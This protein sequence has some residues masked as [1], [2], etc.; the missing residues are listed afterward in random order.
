MTLTISDP[1]R[2]LRGVGA[3]GERELAAAGIATIGQLLWH[4]PFR[5]E[6][7]ARPVAIADLSDVGEVTVR[8]R[9]VRVH[10]RRAWTRGMHLTEALVADPTGELAVVWFNQPYLARLLLPGTQLWLHGRVARP[11]PSHA[12]QMLAPEYEIADDTDP[13]HHGRIVPIYERIGR[14][15]GRRLR[16]MIAAALADLADPIDALDALSLARLGLPE[17]GEALRTVHAPGGDGEG[18]A[19]LTALAER[20]TPAQRR[21]IVE[22]F[23]ALC[24]ALERSRDERLHQ[25]AAVCAVDGAI[26][27]R[28]R[29]LLPFRLTAAQRRVVA[30]IV[31]DLG[32]P[33]PMARLLQGDVGSGKTVVA[34][35]AALVALENGLQVAFLAPTELLARQHAGTLQRLF[36]ATPFAPELLIGSLCVAVKR[37]LTRRMGAGS[38][39]FVIGTH[40]LLE[41]EVRFA[42]LGLVI[43][44]E[45][46]KFGVMQRQALRDK[47]DAPHL[48]VMTA[49]PIPRSVAL[50]MY[51]DLD[52]S[53]LDEAPP[54]RTPIRTVLRG[55]EARTRL[56][57]F[58]RREVAAGGQ[59]YWV[60][61]V[62][63]EQPAMPVRA[64]ERHAGEI[65]AELAGI[66]VAMVHGR[67]KPAERETAM[68][69]FARGEIGVL[70]ATTVI[71]VGVDVANATVMV[72]ENPERLGLAQ[73]HQLRGRVGRGRRRALCVLL[74]GVGASVAARARIEIFAAT[75]DGFQLADEDFRQ[76]GPGELAGLRQWGRARMCI[77]DLGRDRTE[78]E[79]ARR[80][81]AAARTAGRLD[82]LVAALVVPGEGGEVGSG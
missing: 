45:Q 9:V 58:V 71:E 56:L 73:L 50:G 31:A 60:F 30:E 72:I 67:Q 46:H 20:R 36:A 14:L 24:A 81:A 47:G 52:L 4:I 25:C 62:I 1:V 61:P 55:D 68:A 63:E 15:A 33:H 13:V 54:G 70:C 48:L 6:D 43:V 59:V 79:V 51:G 18:G 37:D 26:R 39:R 34:A 57:A 5:W 29:A 17:I 7:R 66:S 64:L 11:D 41:R 82:E 76:R 8:A 80:A 12:V 32:S 22:E 35:L 28:A 42:R 10:E 21:L 2:Q 49:T 77:A 16:G 3:V 75:S 65:A 19:V 78:F 53:V 40:A 38:C 27:A 23:L 44:D 74:I 69:A